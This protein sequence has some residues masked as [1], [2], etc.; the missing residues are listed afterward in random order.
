MSCGIP[1]TKRSNWMKGDWMK[2]SLLLC[3]ALLPSLALAQL[4][5]AGSINGTVTD[6][7]G[8]VIPN[9]T[10]TALN[11]ATGTKSIRS[12]S[13]SGYYVL[14]PLDPGT[15][16]VTVAAKGFRILTQD[17]VVVDALHVVGLNLSLTVG[18]ASENVVVN[19]APP[20]L[21][22]ASATI[23]GTIENDAYIALPLQMNGAPRDPTQFAYLMPG[24]SQ[25]NSGSSGVFDGTGSLGRIDELFLDGLPTTRI[26]Q[27]GDPREVS[28]SISVEAI[29]QF[30]VVTGG[31]PIEYQGVGVQNY[32]MKS[33]ANQIHGS[34]FEFFRN[35]ALDTWSWGSSSLTNPATGKPT[36]P[37]EH[38]NEFGLAAGGP[39]IKNRLFFYGVYEGYRYL[40]YGNFQLGTV[41]T[42]PERSGNFTDLPASQSIYD[43]ATT[44]CTAGQCTRQQFSYNGSKNVID[45]GRISKIS[46]ALINGLP[47]PTNPALVANNWFGP[48][49]N[50]TFTWKASGKL[51]AVI[52][53]KQHAAVVFSSYKSYPYGYTPFAGF[54]IPLPVPWVS[55][56]IGLAY[57]K[58]LL[59]EH[60]YTITNHMVN[61]LKF[62]FFR[63]LSIQSAPTFNPAY[64]AATKY[65]IMG[66]PAGQVSESFPEITF[67]GP[68]A[69]SSFAVAKADNEITNTYDLLDNAQYVRGKH[70]ITAGVVHQ[71]LEDN[72]TFYVTGTSPVTLNYSNAQTAGFTPISGS[73]GGTLSTTQGDAFTSFLLGQVN[74]ASLTDTAAVTSYGRMYPW[75][76]YAEDDYALTRKLTLNLGLRWD[77]FPPFLERENRLSWLNPTLMNP[78]VNY[79]GALVFAGNGASTCNC[80][81]PLNT[82]HKNFGPRLGVAYSLGTKTVLR[83]G[84]TLNFSHASGQNNVGRSGPGNS[85]Y[86]ATPAPVSPSSGV[87]AFILDNGFPSFQ[88][89][90]FLNASFGTGYSTTIVTTPLQPEYADPYYGS[91]APY[92]VDW[93]V[94][95]ERQLTNDLTLEVDYVGTEGHFLNS[96]GNGVGNDARGYWSDLLN[97]VYYSLG[98]LLNATPTPTNLAAAQKI[99]PGIQI[100]YPTFGGSGGTIAQMLRPFPQ[101]NGVED[102]YGDII[103]SNYNAL[104]LVLNKRM[105]NGLNIMANYT[106]SHEIDNQGTFR[107]GYLPTRVERARG[108]GDTPEILNITTVYNLPFGR[109]DMH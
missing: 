24:A 33:G 39:I 104:Q 62:G 65:G 8:A 68:N 36:K 46:E 12:T 103:N 67:A 74:S 71:W 23:G 21:D 17:Q 27:Q 32:V 7:S 83:A 19:T 6:P 31:S 50:S 57:A 25:G 40:N 73:S 69:V 51:D 109:G 72:Y 90:P 14:S 52:N 61:Q 63:A 22:T 95:L 49:I 76:V 92:A 53:Q 44:T 15:Y 96:T 105:S 84:Y 97:P 78:A 106:F 4:S 13:S 5:G 70:S 99:I 82:W 85:G 98:S 28:Y 3:I 66:L 1:S 38:Q 80:R 55:A 101:Y 87:A 54:G 11:T 88:A 9:A 102:A 26:S 108:T 47:L 58:N 81:T 94:G 64:G 2:L 43:P 42:A 77:Y 75:S 41:P 93:N 56:Q 34:L 37:V 48:P 29:D 89:P 60:N 100:P 45:P 30:Q 10:V 20:T 35:T 86:T 79:P 91:R 107:N 16:D 18:T 59:L